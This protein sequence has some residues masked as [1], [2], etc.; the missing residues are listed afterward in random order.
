MAGEGQIDRR[1]VVEIFVRHT[2]HQRATIEH[3]GDARQVLG[4]MDSG[5]RRGDA[6]EFAA[7]VERGLGLGIPHVELTLTA[8]GEH[9]DDRLGTPEPRTAPR[10]R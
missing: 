6:A 4:H 1:A 9:H 5:Q 2:P 8:A 10:S 3:A 7:D